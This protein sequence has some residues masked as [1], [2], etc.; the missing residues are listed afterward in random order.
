M[1]FRRIVSWPRRRSE[2]RPGH[3]THGPSGCVLGAQSGRRTPRS[4]PRFSVDWH[5]L[6]PSPAACGPKPQR[7]LHPL[8]STDPRTNRHSWFGARYERKC[9]RSRS[10][11]EG[12]GSLHRG[13]ATPR[14]RIFAIS[15]RDAADFAPDGVGPTSWRSLHFRRPLLVSDKIRLAPRPNHECRLVLERWRFPLDH[16]LAFPRLDRPGAWGGLAAAHGGGPRVRRA[17]QS[18]QWRGWE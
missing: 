3:E 6:Q 9:F 11:A 2:E 16:D 4:C 7:N 1:G 17:G 15:L 18:P 5:A 8:S 13:F 10:E 14:W 12:G